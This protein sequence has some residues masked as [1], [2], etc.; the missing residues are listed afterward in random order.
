MGGTAR[1]YRE[2]TFERKPPPFLRPVADV[3]LAVSLHLRED[4]RH[5]MKPLEP[6]EPRPFPLTQ[7]SLVG[8]AGQTTSDGQREAL[9]ILLRRYLPAMKT[10]LVLQRRLS[11]D[12]ADDLLQEFVVSK[13]LEQ[14]VIDRSDRDRGKFLHHVLPRHPRMTTGS[15]GYDVDPAQVAEF[16]PLNADFV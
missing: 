15:R 13:V 2:R 11:P 10:Y 4:R 6:E 16:L 12:Q 9:G 1:L 8:L 5:P 7:W 3:N 14:R